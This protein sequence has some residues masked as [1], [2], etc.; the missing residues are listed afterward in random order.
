LW[1]LVDSDEA[2]SV[3]FSRLQEDFGANAKLHI[4]RKREIENYLLSAKAN[5]RHLTA[6][7]RAGNE[8]SFKAPSESDFQAQLNASAEALKP[9]TIWKRVRAA[10]RR[11]IYPGDES[12][13]TPATCGEMK[14]CAQKMLENM[15]GSISSALSS[16]DR[17]CADAESQVESSWQTDKLG[18][19]PGSALLDEVYKK[20]GFRYDK[21]RDGVAVAAHM[22]VDEID[23]EIQDFIK[24]L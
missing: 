5:I 6:R 1:F 16:V 11:P 13:E 24:R 8:K 18:I 3:H 10:T 12:A 7:K 19:V 23:V 20:Y 21:M 15:Q 17:L 4:L 2:T 14:L 9:L 22:D